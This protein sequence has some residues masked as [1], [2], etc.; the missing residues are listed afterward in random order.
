MK[1]TE[2]KFVPSRQKARRWACPAIRALTISDR[3]I[4]IVLLHEKQPVPGWRKIAGLT[5]ARWIPS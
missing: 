3:L 5:R 2:A 4:R 1:A